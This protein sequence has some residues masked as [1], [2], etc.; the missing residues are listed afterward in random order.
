MNPN[1]PNNNNN[2]NTRKTNNVNN[3]TLE[4]SSS[5]GDIPILVT[6]P[7]LIGESR[8][9]SNSSINLNLNSTIVNNS[10]SKNNN[11]S[12]SN[13]HVKTSPNSSSPP[14]PLSPSSAKPPLSPTIQ[15]NN[16]NISNSSTSSSSSSSSSSS[17][18]SNPNT[19]KI[20]TPPLST[21][22]A[23]ATA[24]VSAILT[25]TTTLPLVTSSTIKLSPRN[26]IPS[27]DHQ[28]QQ[29]K[30]Q[31]L[32]Q[33][34]QAAQPQQRMAS[35]SLSSNSNPNVAGSSPLQSP[36]GSGQNSPLN[37]NV[38]S[39]RSVSTPNI[40]A[41]PL[42]SRTSLLSSPR[43]ISPK[44]VL[45]NNNNSSG[46]NNN[47][48]NDKPKLQYS[49]SRSRFTNFDELMDMKQPQQQQ[50][51]H[52]ATVPKSYS[53]PSIGSSSKNNSSTGRITNTH[54]IGGVGAE[55]D[56][57]EEEEDD[58]DTNTDEVKKRIDDAGGEDN[59]SFSDD[60]I[61][62]NSEDFESTDS[63]DSDS[64]DFESTVKLQQQKQLLQQQQHLSHKLQFP[65]L[66][67]SNLHVH[68]NL[69]T[70]NTA[71]ATTVSSPSSH[72]VKNY[73]GSIS[74]N[75]SPKDN[76]NN[77]INNQT[78]QHQQ[79]QPQTKVSPTSA[80]TTTTSTTT[81]T[82]TTN[83][84]SNSTPT[85]S[86]PN[87]RP[88][89]QSQSTSS[90]LSGWANKSKE[91]MVDRKK[92][93]VTS[94]TKQQQHQVDDTIELGSS[95]EFEQRDG[96]LNL[97][98][99]PT[100][101]TTQTTSPS[102][103]E[104][105]SNHS[106]STSPISTNNSMTT[107][108][109]AYFTST[110]KQQTTATGTESSTEQ[111]QQQEDNTTTT[112]TTSTGTVT[113]TGTSTGTGTS[114]SLM[115]NHRLL[116]NNN[117]NNN[118]SLLPI[119]KV[120]SEQ[121]QQQPPKQYK[122]SKH[123]LQRGY[124]APIINNTATRKLTL[125]EILNSSPPLIASQNRPFQKQSL[126]SVQN[127]D[128]T[129]PTTKSTSLPI[130]AASSPVRLTQQQQQQS[131]VY[132]S[133]A[134]TSPSTSPASSPSM[135]SK[136]T[137]TTPTTT[138][139]T[140][141][142]ITNSTSVS[143][144]LNST[145][146]NVSKSNTNSPIPSPMVMSPSGVSPP[147][148]T[149]SMPSS[150]MPSSSPLVSTPPMS[151]SYAI[152]KRLIPLSAYSPTSSNSPAA[153]MT[154]TL[155]STSPPI[156]RAVH[157]HQRGGVGVAGS[158]QQQQQHSSTTPNIS[159]SSSPRSSPPHTPI[160]QSPVLRFKFPHPM[161]SPLS[162]DY[163][164]SSSDYPSSVG[165]PS[166]A[167][168]YQSTTTSLN[169]P[170]N[171]T[172]PFESQTSNS[173]NDKL[174]RTINQL[175]HQPEQLTKLRQ[176]VQ[177]LVYENVDKSVHIEINTT[178]RT[179]LNIQRNYS[180]SLI[181]NDKDEI[182]IANN[183]N[184]NNDNLDNNN[185]NINNNDGEKEVISTSTTTTTTTTTTSSFSPATNIIIS[186]NDNNNNNNNNKTSNINNSNSHSFNSTIK[187]S[188]NLLP[189]LFT[190]VPIY[191]SKPHLLVSRK[192]TSSIHSEYKYTPSSL[193]PSSSASTTNSPSTSTNSSGSSSIKSSPQESPVLSPTP[194][195]RAG[196]KV[197][198]PLATGFDIFDLVKKERPSAAR[199]RSEPLLMSPNSLTPRSHQQKTAATNTANTSGSRLSLSPLESNTTNSASPNN[200]S[201]LPSPT[202]SANSS[203]IKTS[204]P[205]QIGVLSPTIT[206]PSL[207][208]RLSGNIVRS[209]PPLSSTLISPRRVDPTVIVTNNETSSSTTT[210]S[211]TTSI[212]SNNTFEVHSIH[213]IGQTKSTTPILSKTPT[214]I[215]TSSSGLVS[216][217]ISGSLQVH[218]LIEPSI[219]DPS[220]TFSSEKLLQQIQSMNNKQQQQQFD[221]DLEVLESSPTGQVMVITLLSNW[222][223]THSITLAMIRFW[224]YNKSR[225]H[226]ARGVKDIEITLDNSL[227]F[228]GVIKRASGMLSECDEC[229][230]YIIFN[231]DDSVLDLIEQN[232]PY[233]P[234]SL[235]DEEEE[236]FLEPVNSNAPTED[237]NNLN[238]LPNHHR[239]ENMFSRMNVERDGKLASRRASES[240]FTTVLKREQLQQQEQM[241]QLE[242]KSSN[243]KDICKE[244]IN[245]ES[246]PKGRLLKIQ[247][248][249][250]WGDRY[251]LGL[252]S[253][254]VYDENYQ[255][256]KL[257]LSNLIANPK[258]I[259]DLPGH[260]GD[261]R[262]LDKL[263]DGKNV[264]TDDQ[265][266]WMIPFRQKHQ[267]DQTDYH[268]TLDLGVETT[269]SCLRVWNYNKNADDASRGAKEVVISL[270]GKCLT[271]GYIFRKA[272]GESNFDYGQT[273]SFIHHDKHSQES[274]SE[275]YDKMM[276]FSKQS[277]IPQDYKTLFIPSGFVFKFVL[278][279]SWGDKSY[280]GLNGMQL[281]DW[282]EDLIDVSKSRTVLLPPAL[283][284]ASNDQTLSR[285]F[286]GINSG[287][288][289]KHAWC[290]HALYPYDRSSTGLIPISICLYF[291]YP[292]SLSMVKIWNYSRVP[293]RGVEE[294]AM[295]IDDLLLFKG[296]LSP[297]PTYPST[298]VDNNHDFSQTILFSHNSEHLQ[299]EKIYRFTGSKQKVNFI[300]NNNSVKN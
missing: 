247:F 199:K 252:T 110:F 153:A 249:S 236:S 276:I 91:F 300:N 95:S 132:S 37:S 271:S 43:N 191:K 267:H 245:N 68:S 89:N 228:K 15:S 217:N 184:N 134:N 244:E 24:T 9:R 10:N 182:L 48:N 32:Q 27:E 146:Q 56:E 155:E 85:T 92:Q 22:P 72:R 172:H 90:I 21:S 14:V 2:N 231:N 42:N 177:S 144:S 248:K 103:N 116:N 76:P 142:T 122:S 97:I 190:P 58:T 180:H 131:G 281:F 106:L 259:N 200:S 41:I 291:D 238:K 165:S 35:K 84:N 192:S 62:L 127:K 158:G 208:R 211:T 66:Q 152:P 229:A 130:T 178:P 117:N 222:G 119:P 280:L 83:S 137:T 194:S 151:V 28:I 100:K 109:I 44:T 73:G 167:S 253:I 113:I 264:T 213:S 87:R 187:R 59:S 26:Y 299:K 6:S 243:T 278:L 96:K 203:P 268:L 67:L 179:L 237:E 210:T 111:Q 270:D 17:G 5:S 36:A 52:Q 242:R 296:K 181:I 51:Q 260:S 57:E 189:P 20:Q 82:T 160:P 221:Q 214:A 261:Y 123:P 171:K 193:M 154:P 46:N 98:P 186:N 69:E 75:P 161:R 251:Y 225:I 102:N 128:S 282:N 265:H 159:P 31:V 63:E 29:I 202:A 263:I 207:C 220:M 188:S 70:N 290:T 239:I 234:S 61:D 60:S 174:L 284:N 136:P 1:N 39:P 143:P 145:I 124:S 149:P 129:S 197:P 163:P 196:D 169:P 298:S 49:S 34:Q 274:I 114:P 47:N 257:Q 292:I 250:T 230:E 16:I 88:L 226:S 104:I 204:E 232:D 74:A 272:P 164:S 147:M 77:N 50:P 233:S 266:M 71:A 105:D 223:D 166:S 107:S 86:S 176:F 157:K 168:S 78:Q 205:P 258:D 275:S 218:D 227:I 273:L 198:P 8:A 255:L 13:K 54:L 279:S 175:I 212:F 277:Y 79:Q 283:N 224:N 126:L 297:S 108:P 7:L 99:I 30:K 33:Q 170:N 19:P 121:Q 138:S 141:T 3:N 288:D 209:L 235:D 120:E 256:I 262:T 94:T 38:N 45:N 216:N 25:S 246:L 93:V 219:S 287:F 294:F 285:L 195:P 289:E 254:E 64:Y 140:T 201:S 185:N 133:P 23:T 206:R 156:G 162:Y 183:N 150:P 81:A 139:T 241:L 295:Y 115:S 11:N 4:N 173:P 215:T 80:T 112:T 65:Q 148:S 12:N 18:N 135:K 118:K 286:D 125:Q 240:D 53:S 293:T 55:D 40:L 101:P 269:L